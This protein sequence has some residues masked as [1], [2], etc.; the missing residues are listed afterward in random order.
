MKHITSLAANTARALCTG[1]IALAIP[2][3]LVMPVMP[4]A[5]QTGDINA[6]VGALR[7][8][9]TM[10]ARFV[11]IGRGGQQL[12]G[13]MYLKRPGKIRFQYANEVGLL[14]VSDGS[15]LTM[16]D[17]DVN[18][19]QVW[20]IK[21]SPLAA[22][23]DPSRD[24]AQYATLMPTEHPDVVSLRVKDPEH[25]EYGVMTLIFQRAA[26]APGGMQL[27]GWVAVDSQNKVTKIFLENQ[28]YGLEVSENQFRYRDINPRPKR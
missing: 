2:A 18:Q 21:R 9:G 10:K 20:P 13:V 1:A 14:I 11:Q 19:K 22:L 7:A 12:T 27:E 17:Y 25:P 23:L 5:A 28:Q 15:R 3:A 26:N 16:I 4:A 6:A 8:I 24:V